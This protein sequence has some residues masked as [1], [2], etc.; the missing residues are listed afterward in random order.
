MK[1]MEHILGR[2]EYDAGTFYQKMLD[3]AAG[4]HGMEIRRMSK[5]T[6]DLLAAADYPR[7]KRKR[8][9]N[10]QL[11][12][13]LLPSDSVFNR[14]IP[15]GPFAYPYYHKDGMRLRKWLAGRKIFVPVNWRNVLENF[16]EDTMEYDWSANVLPLPCD[17]RY[18][19]EE[20][21]YVAESIREWEETE[22]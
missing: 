12:A 2:Y 1:R 6:H 7:I 15:E 11:L 8:E 17:Q 10:H 14:T 19:E 13:A 3:N 18:G 16:E 9:E 5:L 22:A 21:R 4:Y 20:M